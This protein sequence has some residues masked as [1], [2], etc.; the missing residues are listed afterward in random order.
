M[1]RR[2]VHRASAPAPA[3]PCSTLQHPRGQRV[4]DPDAGLQDARKRARVA[5]LAAFT[6]SHQLLV[7]TDADERLA[8]LR[9]ALTHSVHAELVDLTRDDDSGADLSDSSDDEPQKQQQMQSSSLTQQLVRK[10]HAGANPDDTA[11]GSSSAVDVGC[12]SG[13][14]GSATAADSVTAAWPQLPLSLHQDIHNISSCASADAVEED[15][16]VQQQQQQQQQLQAQQQRLQAQQQ[17]QPEHQLQQQDER[18]QQQQDAQHEQ[19]VLATWT[20]DTAALL[21]T[22]HPNRLFYEHEPLHACIAR[23]L[24]ADCNSPGTPQL[25][26]PTSALGGGVLG[27]ASPGV[28]TTGA[29]HHAQSRLQQ[30]APA[31]WLLCT[32]P[33]LAAKPSLLAALDPDTTQQ[34]DQGLQA[35][36]ETTTAV[37]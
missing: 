32:P 13:D 11:L 4:A 36:L 19:H 5:C 1:K 29:A 31:E 16:V 35:G 22:H 27:D 3:A 2:S 6:P 15:I 28:A 20:S 18:Q 7:V 37:P 30:H 8:R 24:A 10:Q 14:P 21:S 26:A 23:E 17:Q 34:A 9:A 33:P 12:V 25:S